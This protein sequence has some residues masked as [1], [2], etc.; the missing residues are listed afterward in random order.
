MHEA[1]LTGKRILVIEDIIE[2][3]RLF[4]AILKMD[5][6]EVLSASNARDG[7]AFARSHEP[8]LILMDI[9]MPEMDGLTATRIL[10]ADPDTTA[11]PIVAVTASVMLDD[12]NDTLEAGC[13]GYIT[14]PLEPLQFARQLLPYLQT[15]AAT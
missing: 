2:N 9:H 13:N 15:K 7:I 4:E 11:I 14:K 10:R 1:L 5:G 12:L 8:D 6:A 3:M